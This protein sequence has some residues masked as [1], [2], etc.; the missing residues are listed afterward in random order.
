MPT[1]AVS[2]SYVCRK[3]FNDFYGDEGGFRST[4]SDDSPGDELYFL[5]IID[6]LTPY[7]SKKK[8]EHLIKSIQHDKVLY[9]I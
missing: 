3:K 1:S 8:V 4:L 9:S 6:I 2:L 7:T 5:G